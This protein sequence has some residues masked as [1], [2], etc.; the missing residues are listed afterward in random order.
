[1]KDS[2]SIKGFLSLV[3]RFNLGLSIRRAPQEPDGP[4]YQIGIFYPKTQRVKGKKVTKEFSPF[5][6][7]YPPTDTSFESIASD[8]KRII[9]K[10]RWKL[11][12]WK[13]IPGT[14]ND[15]PYAEEVDWGTYHSLYQCLSK[16]VNNAIGDII[17][18]TWE[19]F[20]Y[21]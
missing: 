16:V 6:D 8:D 21:K 11:T 2:T 9:E 3:K 4:L 19:N 18:D 14:Y 20:E 17:N 10:T 12:L 5:I 1:M 7:I 15:P 13:Y